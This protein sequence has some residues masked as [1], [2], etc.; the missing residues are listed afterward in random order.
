M[1]LGLKDR[2][3]IVT[4]SSQGIGKDIAYGLAQEGAKVTICARNEEAL[5]KT[6]GEIRSLTK[7]EVLPVKAD[8]SGK[9]SIKYMVTAT[10]QRFDK[11][12]ILVNNTGGPPSALF[13]ETSEEDWYETANSLL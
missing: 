6:A 1:D 5:K 7:A 12:D 2:V 11:L 4:G 10:I 9:E 8:L 3:A 13:M